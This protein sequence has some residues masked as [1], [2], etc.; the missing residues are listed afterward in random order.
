[1]G[2]ASDMYATV[3]QQ[4]S[5]AVHDGGIAARIRAILYSGRRDDFMADSIKR[6]G[7]V[8]P[9]HMGSAFA[10]NLTEDGYEVSVFGRHFERTR[11]QFGSRA[12]SSLADLGNCE[13]VFTSLP[14]DDALFDVAL[15]DGGLVSAL[16]DG[17]VH[18]STSTVSPGAARRVAAA[19]RDAGQSYVAVPVLGNPTF[20]SERKLYL[21]MAGDPSVLDSVG[22]MVNRLGQRSFVIGEDPGLANLM[23]LA[24]NALTATTLQCMGEVLALTEK[25]G[26]DGH[27]AFDTLTHSM[28]DGHV[29]IS[30]GS[31]IVNKEYT[32]PGL[33]VPLALKD[34]RLALAEAE[35]T[36]AP[37]PA[38]SLVHDRLV[39]MLARGWDGLDWSALG[40]LALDEAGLED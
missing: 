30:Y 22:P 26:I 28:F 15:G 6:V 13:A 3:R 24:A 32:P 11:E 31:K 10:K 4:L 1:V 29:H 38:T 33:A 37:M 12:V 17:A 18:V 35:H 8:G 16:K 19:H 5:S 27:L 2:R 39:A 25:G 20:A 7:V 14:D 9:G 40:K 23:K 21:L 36:S 34:I